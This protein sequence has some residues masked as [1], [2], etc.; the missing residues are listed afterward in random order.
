MILAAGL[1]T[2]LWPLTA[3]RGKPA[4]PFLGRPLIAGMAALARAH[5]F[6]K[7]VVNTHHQPESI[8]AALLGLESEVEIVYSHED[9]ILGTAGALALARDRGLLDTDRPTMVLNGKLHIDLDLRAI[10][11]THEESGALVTPR[12]EGGQG[13]APDAEGRSCG[14]RTTTNGRDDP[15]DEFRALSAHAC[16]RGVRP[17]ASVSGG[18]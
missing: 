9:E 1:G 4:V 16:P 2:R 18:A 10:A 5:R 17:G 12:S 13:W 3:D 6:R 15:A 14:P 7:I 11:Q 8:Q